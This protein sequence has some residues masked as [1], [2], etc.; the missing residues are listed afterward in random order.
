MEFDFVNNENELIEKS[1]PPNFLVAANSILSVVLLESQILI[2]R[3]LF[4]L[5]Y[6]FVLI[7]GDG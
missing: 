5:W 4:Y 1:Y 6:V 7:E 2:K 3:S